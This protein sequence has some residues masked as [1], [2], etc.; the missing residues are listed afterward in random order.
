MGLE[1][2]CTIG[3]ITEGKNF[4]A[5][6]TRI[7]E[8]TSITWQAHYQEIRQLLGLV[9]DFLENGHEFNYPKITGV[10]YSNNLEVKDWGK[11]SGKKGRNTKV[12]AMNS[13]GKSKM[14]KDWVALLEKPEY[15]QK[16]QKLLGFTIN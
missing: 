2:K 15:L 12:T 6:Q 3:T 7:S 13:S 4:R 16:Y 1:V 10:F 5:G 14:G 8:L 11:I 9:W